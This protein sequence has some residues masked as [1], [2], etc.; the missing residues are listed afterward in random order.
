MSSVCKKKKVSFI[1]CDLRRIRLQGKVKK[2]KNSKSPPDLNCDTV[3]IE[4]NN[5]NFQKIGP[6]SSKV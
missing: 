6:L 4:V 1:Y 3:K 2:K 5:K